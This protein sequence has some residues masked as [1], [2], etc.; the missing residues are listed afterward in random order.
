[1]NKQKAIKYLCWT[2]TAL[3]EDNLGDAN[4]CLKWAVEEIEDD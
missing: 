2:I 1:M 4:N 3:A